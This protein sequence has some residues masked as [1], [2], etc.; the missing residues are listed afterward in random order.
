MSTGISN[1]HYMYM[2]QAFQDTEATHT[3][4]AEGTV[5]VVQD[6]YSKDC[7]STDTKKPRHM[8]SF[9]KLKNNCNIFKIR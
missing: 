1:Q 2:N 8:N 9:E 3:S 7:S 5:P 6:E 4:A